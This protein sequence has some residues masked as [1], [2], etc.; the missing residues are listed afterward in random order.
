MN[1]D[2]IIDL[3]E[4]Y[5]IKDDAMLKKI[6]GGCYYNVPIR[7]DSVPSKEELDQIIMII[8]NLLK[9]N[10]KIYINCRLGR[11]RSPTILIAYMISKLRN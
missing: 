5:E 4:K 9:M 7:D 10:K 8:D 3:R 1:I 6:T 2:C 11:G